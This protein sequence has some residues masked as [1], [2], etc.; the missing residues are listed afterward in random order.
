MIGYEFGGQVELKW[1]LNWKLVSGIKIELWGYRAD[2]MYKQGT[3]GIFVETY[4]AHQLKIPGF[5]PELY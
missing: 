2:P 1:A 3:K 4:I 5:I